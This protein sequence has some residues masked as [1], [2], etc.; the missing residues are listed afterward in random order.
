[1]T[2]EPDTASTAA[3]QVLD[4]AAQLGRILGQN[5]RIRQLECRC[6][7]IGVAYAQGTVS[8]FDENSAVQQLLGVAT[9]V[10]A[11]TT[12]EGTSLSAALHTPAFH[13]LAAPRV[14]APTAPEQ[15]QL[16][17]HAGWSLQS[18]RWRLRDALDD[19]LLADQKGDA[20]AAEQ[21]VRRI[22]AHFHI[23]MPPP[24]TPR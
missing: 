24:R 14:L 2:A 3:G 9:T 8:P 6:V 11:T 16:P 17:R 13:L 10:T 21:I 18:R 19:L 7:S 15:P 23:P 20:A 22:A 5:V 4:H 12:P 1:M